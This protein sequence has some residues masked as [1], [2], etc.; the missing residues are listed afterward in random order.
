MGEGDGYGVRTWIGGSVESANAMSAPESW[1]PAYEVKREREEGTRRN[2][3]GANLQ[4]S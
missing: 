2:G 4:V 3:M 1:Y